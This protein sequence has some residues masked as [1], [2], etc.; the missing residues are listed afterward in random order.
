MINLHALR[1]GKP[2]ESMETDD[3]L[4]FLTG[5][6]IAKVSQAGGGI[7]QRDMR[8]AKRA[9]DVLREIPIAELTEMMKTAAEL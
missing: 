5:E 8:K 6:P 1:W 4:H 2:Y 7:V 9:R 3:V